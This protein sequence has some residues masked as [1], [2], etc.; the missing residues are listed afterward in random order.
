M[1]HITSTVIQLINY[2][3]NVK[4]ILLSAVGPSA[5]KNL[6]F[7]VRQIVGKLLLRRLKMSNFVS[8]CLGGVV[9][10]S[11]LYHLDHKK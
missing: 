9:T 7:N 4:T 5:V 1:H 8:L 11:N 10:P 6:P 2:G 3:H